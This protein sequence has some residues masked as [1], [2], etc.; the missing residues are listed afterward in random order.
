M[1]IFFF[2]SFQAILSIYSCEK[3]TEE[4]GTNEE[5]EEREREGELCQTD[6]DE[7]MSY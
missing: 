4:Y 7:Q 2:S 1:P 3:R 6:F 5:E